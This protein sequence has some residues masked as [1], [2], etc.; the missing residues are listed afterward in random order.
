MQAK[1]YPS[2][3]NPV[4]IAITDLGRVHPLQNKKHRSGQFNSKL[5]LRFRKVNVQFD[6]INVFLK[7]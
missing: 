1:N 7:S 5:K 2:H 6:R 3:T 4:R